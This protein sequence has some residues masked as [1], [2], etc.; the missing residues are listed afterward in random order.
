MP[1]TSLRRLRNGLL[2]R[3][4]VSNT[5]G[6]FPLCT[7]AAAALCLPFFV[8][9]RCLMG[10]PLGIVLPWRGR[11]WSVLSPAR[12]MMRLAEISS[13]TVMPVSRRTSTRI[14]GRLPVVLPSGFSVS[15]ISPLGSVKVVSLAALQVA[16]TSNFRFSWVLSELPPAL[17]VGTH[18]MWSK[19]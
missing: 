11:D 3:P 7:A 16:W 15:G 17:P 12:S 4:Y 6:K 9:S 1:A 5:S 13:R 19:A 10:S 8:V 18:H 14:S 2:V